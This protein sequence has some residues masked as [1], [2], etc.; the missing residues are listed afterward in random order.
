MKN[1]KLLFVAALIVVIISIMFTFTGQESDQN[2][3]QEI[4]QERII[5]DEF[6]AS[7]KESPLTDADKE[8]FTGLFYFPVDEKF[9]VEAD[10]ERITTG[11]RISMATSDGKV[12]HYKKYAYVT[13]TIDGIPLKLVLY[14][15]A[16]PPNNLLFLPFADKT[17]ADETYGGGRYLDFDLPRGDAMEIDFNLAYN[18]YCVFSDDYSCP[19]PP[20]ENVLAVAIKAGEKNY[21]KN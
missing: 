5:K 4:E 8:E 7:S 14:Q 19:L 15:P 13:F 17:S 1:T 16:Q 2:Y 18:P 6:M 21:T 20:R 12:K 3:V 11:E 10:I 9:K